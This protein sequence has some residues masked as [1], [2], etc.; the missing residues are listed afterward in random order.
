M[1]LDIT[2]RISDSQNYLE[3][4]KK[5]ILARNFAVYIKNLYIERVLESLKSGR[6]RGKWEPTN[7]D[8]INFKTSKGLPEKLDIEGLIKNTIGVYKIK[9]YYVVGLDR[10]RMYPKTTT[11]LQQIIRWLE[12]GS[13]KNP[14]RPLLSPV[15]NDI[16]KNLKIYWGIF[17]ENHR[18]FILDNIKRK[19]EE[20]RKNDR[21][22]DIRQKR[23]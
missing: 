16:D 7:E 13:S 12:F 23:F 20:S 8:Y 22:R 11:L 10:Y 2:I 14:A 4:D 5:D 18:E 1:L 21:S 17:L 6:Y 9:D 19:K 3:K 15:R